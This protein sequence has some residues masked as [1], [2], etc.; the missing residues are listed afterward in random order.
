MSDH[1]QEQKQ[2][3]EQEQKQEQEHEHEQEQEQEQEHEHDVF[4][5]DEMPDIP[6]AVRSRRRLSTADYRSKHFDPS[7][8]AEQR[9]AASPRCIAVFTSGGDASGTGHNGLITVYSGVDIRGSPASEITICKEGR[10]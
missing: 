4:G 8:F 7:I 5:E 6:V 10:P 1:E 2:E 3:H 9:S